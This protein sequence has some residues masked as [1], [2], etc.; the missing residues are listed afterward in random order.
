MKKILTILASALFIAVQLQAQIEPKAGKWKTWFI[1]SA[2]D[3][4]LQGPPPYKNEIAQV[5]SR[6]QNLDS[7]TR[8]QIVY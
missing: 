4:R 1:S 2:K 8:Q 3:Y 6:Q 5:I 7:A